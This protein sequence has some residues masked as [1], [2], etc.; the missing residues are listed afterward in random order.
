[1]DS[2]THLVLGASM[3]EAILGKKIGKRAMLWGALANNLP[4]IDV[5]FVPFFDAPASFT[6]HRGITHSVLFAA[7]MAPLFGNLFSRINPGL[8]SNFRSWTLLFFTELLAHIVLDSFTAYG[9]GWFEPFS[10]YR[11]S[12]N[13]I[14]VADPFY[15]LPLIVCVIALILL[16]THSP[17][18]KKWNKAGLLIS[19]AYLVFTFINKAYVDHTFAKAMKEQNITHTRYFSTPTPLNNFLWMGV[20]EDTA[21]FYV[22]YYSDFDRNDKIIFNRLLKNEQLITNYPDQDM[23]K[24]LKWFSDNYYCITLEDSA[25][26]FND[27]RFGQMWGWKDPHAPFAFRFDLD[28][29]GKRKGIDRRKFKG[30]LRENLRILLDRIKGI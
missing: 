28:E 1:M 4:D 26:S 3:G 25:F 16:K 21:G 20:A 5:F 15:T 29:Q 7:V 6:V 12:F 30:S 13:S 11:I 8:N 19:T 23:I 14:F 27:I 9:T 22:G 10:H 24:G 18:R 2:V 17:A